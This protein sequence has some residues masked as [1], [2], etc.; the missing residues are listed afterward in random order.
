MGQ[1]ARFY[2]ENVSNLTFADLVIRSIGSLGYRDCF[3]VTGGA[4]GYLFDALER[5]SEIK[6]H[7][8]VHEQACAMACDAYF[9]FFGRPAFLLVTNGPGVSNTITGI[10]GAFQDSIPIF[11]VSGQVPMRFIP[12]REDGLRQLGVQ[13]ADAETLVKGVVKRF[14]RMES[15]NDLGMVVELDDVMRSHRMGPTWLEIP[16][17]V[18]SRRISPADSAQL[19]VE[20]IDLESANQQRD[21][22]KVDER[23]MTRLQLALEVAERP[24][25]VLGNGVHLAGVEVLTSSFVEALGIPFVC[26][27]SVADLVEFQNPNYVGNFGILGERA[28]NVALQ[29]ADFLLV[30][31]CRLSVPNIGYAVQ[32]FSPGSFKAMVDIDENELTK[33]TLDIDLPIRADLR[34]FFALLKTAGLQTGEIEEWATHLQNLKM[35]LRLE[36]EKYADEHDGVD[37]YRVI[38]SL[39]GVLEN[40]D[41]VVTDM[42]SSFTVTMQA[43]RRNGSTRVITSSGT[44]SMGFGLPGALGIALADKS[45]RILCIAGDGGFQMNLQETQ[46]WVEKAPNLKLIILDSNGYLAISLMQENLFGGRKFGSTAE[47][48]VKSP[49]FVRVLDAYGINV[50]EVSSTHVLSA[51]IYELSMSES[52]SAVVVKLPAG[53]VMRPRV[54]TRLDEL[55]QATSPRLD[56]MWPFDE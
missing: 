46:T 20:S 1:D 15:E 25:I 11:C 17:D 39:S 40:F 16:M 37:A 3:A 30:L 9:R 53:Q 7:F 54:Q 47:T 34:D 56:Q 29:Q 13:E 48:G 4:A 22:T 42:G 5:Q 10:L 43:L 23:I 55:G 52:A 31:G 28:A 32:D 21:S 49:D 45:K 35:T 41:A 24:L 44:S 2:G 19:I 6:V 50:E 18:Q 51:A 33:P 8:L 26:T 38:K 14:S 12:S 36:I 27:W